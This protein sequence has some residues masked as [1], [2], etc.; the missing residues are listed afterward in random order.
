MAVKIGNIKVANMLALGCLLA[1]KK[2][3]SE[4]TVLKIIEKMAPK[5]K[6]QL[7]AINQEA[8]NKGLEL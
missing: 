6:P 2:I 5:D 1:K 7:I 4:K 3:V 8:L